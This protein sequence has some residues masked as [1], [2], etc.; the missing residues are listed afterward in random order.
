MLNLIFRVISV[1][2][3][4]VNG[5]VYFRGQFNYTKY[6]LRIEDIVEKVEGHRLF[7]NGWYMLEGR[8]KKIVWGERRKSIW[9]RPAFVHLEQAFRDI[10]EHGKIVS[11][12]VLE[13]YGEVKCRNLERDFE[14]SYNKML[15]EFK[16]GHF[17]QPSHIFDKNIDYFYVAINED[18]KPMF[19]TGKHRLILAK[20][21]GLTHIPA[22]VSLFH[23]DSIALFQK[24]HNNKN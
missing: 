3:R 20:I 12:P 2:I 19:I 13:Y 23:S 6:N 8:V 11:Q 15:I 22:R 9:D 21:A 18:G 16:A 7:L 1:L 17:G 10:I 14:K 5:L 24:K 4:F